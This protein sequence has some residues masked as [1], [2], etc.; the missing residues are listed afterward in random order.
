MRSVNDVDP[1]IDFK[2]VINSVERKSA[3]TAECG[4]QVEEA[5]TA[6]L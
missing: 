4:R 6:L 5:L 2:H 1:K 3:L